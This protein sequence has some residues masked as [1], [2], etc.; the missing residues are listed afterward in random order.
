MRILASFARRRRS[1]GGDG[2]VFGKLQM[3]VDTEL[4][5]EEIL[6]KLSFWA[7]EY[8]LKLMTP[9][10][11]FRLPDGSFSH[12][13]YRSGFPLFS[14]PIFIEV[15]DSS[16]P[17]VISGWVQVPFFKWKLIETNAPGILTLIDLRRRGGFFCA[18]LKKLLGG[19]RLAVE[20][21]L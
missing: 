6:G 13:L 15:D 11:R 2:R 21:P 1:N 3:S 7:K 14:S 5:R 9:H 19:G 18:E 12:S 17:L 8:R 16:R 20:D 10:L 4:P